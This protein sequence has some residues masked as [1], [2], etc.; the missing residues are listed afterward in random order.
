[1]SY[2]IKQ[3]DEHRQSFGSYRYA[4]YWGK[5]QVAEFWHNYRGECEGIKVLENGHSE[6]PPFGM[7]SDFL[8]GGGPLPL[9]LS[10]EAV[11]YLGKLLS[12][13]Q[14]HHKSLY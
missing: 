13:D 5:K 6:D 10:D 14:T 7:S 2:T 8:T 4:I 3:I 1:M 11:Q 12:T 9:G